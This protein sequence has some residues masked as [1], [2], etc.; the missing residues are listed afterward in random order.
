M[1]HQSPRLRLQNEQEER[2]RPFVWHGGSIGTVLE[3]TGTQYNTSEEN[4][5][6][7]NER[8]ISGSHAERDG[9]EERGANSGGV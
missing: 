9:Q 3:M 4:N 7:A 5:D 2:A 8:A 1:G 6:G